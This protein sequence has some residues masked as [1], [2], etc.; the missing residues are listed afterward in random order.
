MVYINFFNLV[1]VALPT[2]S[3]S[4][5]QTLSVSRDMGKGKEGQRQRQIG[6]RY[7]LVNEGI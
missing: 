7:Y 1:Q 3:L 4:N 2:G 6:N 5:C